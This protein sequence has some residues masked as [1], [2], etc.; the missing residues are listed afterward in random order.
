M[1]KCENCGCEHQ[2]TYGTGRFCSV[3]CARGFSTKEKRSLINEKLKKVDKKTHSNTC[4]ICNSIFTHKRKTIKT[5][6]G[7]CLK[8]L[9]ALK[10]QSNVVC[11]NGGYRKGSGR[12]KSGWYESKIA[13]LVY[14]DSSY[15]F[16]YAKYLDKNNIQWVRNT[17]RFYYNDKNYYIPDFFLTE[18]NLYIEIKGYSTAKDKLKW[19]S[20]ENIKVLFRNDV[21]DLGIQLQ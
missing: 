4:V 6:S 1:N 21:L 16:A 10:I 3:K 2:G 15:E 18:E 17:K 12:G 20:V 8:D 19:E 14:L 5:C 13:G 11:M 9:R 7:K